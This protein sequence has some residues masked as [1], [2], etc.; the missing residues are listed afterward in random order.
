[1]SLWNNATLEEKDIDYI[2]TSMK[3]KSSELFNYGKRQE[4]VK[5][6][7]LRLNCSKLFS[8]LYYLHVFD[9]PSCICG[10]ILEDCY[11]YLLECPLYIIPRQTMLQSLETYLDVNNIDVN[12][13]L[14]GS[15][16]L[17]FKENCEVFEIVHTF[18][19]DSNRL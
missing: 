13:L 1:M 12:T 4:N 19:A 16:D 15:N 2:T 6:A 10:H 14:Y 9:T 5:H 7:Q 8:H 3:T 18:I 11:H 17:D